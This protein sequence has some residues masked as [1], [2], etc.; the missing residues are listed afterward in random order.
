MSPTKEPILGA[1]DRPADPDPDHVLIYGSPPP[2]WASHGSA[3][4]DLVFSVRTRG[5]GRRARSAG[6]WA[7]AID[8][9]CAG[10]VPS[11]ALE[12]CF[13][14]SKPEVIRLLSRLRRAGLL[15]TRRRPIAP[16]M[17]GRRARVGQALAGALARIQARVAGA[18]KGLARPVAS[19]AVYSAADSRYQL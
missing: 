17:H 11:F 19:D 9:M 13:G 12:G 8:A 7:G 6:R 15:H 2:Q 10:D 14:L 18:L 3:D 4:H 1:A 5:R 16:A